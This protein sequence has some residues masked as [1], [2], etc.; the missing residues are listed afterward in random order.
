MLDEDVE[1]NLNISTQLLN[2]LVKAM[3]SLTDDG[4][5]YVNQAT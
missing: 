2:V 4:N 3:N 1:F 5:K